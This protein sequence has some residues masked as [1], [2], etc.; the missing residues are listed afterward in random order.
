M[1]DEEAELN[2]PLSPLIN[3][4]DRERLL[5][6]ESSK[7]SLSPNNGKKS[8]WT[9]EDSLKNPAPYSP[10]M[11]S[12]ERDRFFSPVT[13]S[14]IE[15]SKEDIRS[16]QTDDAEEVRRRI[17]PPVIAASNSNLSEHDE[18]EKTPRESLRSRLR[19]MNASKNRTESL[20]KHNSPEQHNSKLDTEMMILDE[21]YEV[22]QPPPNSLK[23]LRRAGG[24]RERSRRRLRRSMS[25]SNLALRLHLTPNGSIEPEKRLN[26]KLF[27]KIAQLKSRIKEIETRREEETDVLNQHIESL[28]RARGEHKNTIDLLMKEV[29]SGEHEE[30]A[31]LV[32]PPINKSDLFN[33]WSN[34]NVRDRKSVV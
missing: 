24:L 31:I 34:S 18:K 21:E 5:S 4:T 22:D 28:T 2:I 1:S 30:N 27:G 10:L 7:L 12:K 33:A 13:S 6:P 15:E 9:S 23:R 19:K 11:S 3:E 29:S 16:Q 20:S 26:S 25:E 32:K 8:S 14:I 17:I